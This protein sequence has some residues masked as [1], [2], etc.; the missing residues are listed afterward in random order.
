M[1]LRFRGDEGLAGLN[2]NDGQGRTTLSGRYINLD[3]VGTEASATDRRTPP[4]LGRG[5]KYISFRA[6]PWV[7]EVV[8]RLAKKRPDLLCPP[9]LTRGQTHQHRSEGK[10]WWWRGT[11]IG[12]AGPQLGTMGQARCVGQQPRQN[13]A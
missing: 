10:A 2:A 13:G 3:N 5:G 12:V 6:D 8:S 9:G 1:R 11:T 7:S 4:E